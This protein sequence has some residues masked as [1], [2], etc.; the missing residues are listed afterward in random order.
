MRR[1][2]R[3]WGYC[4]IEEGLSDTQ[5]QRL[6]IRLLEQAEGERLAGIEQQSPYGQYVY[7]LINKGECF[8]GC[9]EQDPGAVQCGPVIEQIMDETLEGVDL[10]CFSCSWCRSGQMA[11][12]VTCRSRGAASMDH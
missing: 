7:S 8:A 12:R 3:E 9:I 2:L 10:P 11:T 6:K 5:H 1:D 4:L